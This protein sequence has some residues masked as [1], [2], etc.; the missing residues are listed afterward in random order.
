MG[1]QAKKNFPMGYLS[2]IKKKKTLAA[3]DVG[4]RLGRAFSCHRAVS[5]LDKKLRSIYC[6][7]SSA[8]GVPA[9]GFRGNRVMNFSVA[10]G[11]GEALPS[12]LASLFRAVYAFRVTWSERF[13][14]RIRHRNELT[15]KAWEDAVQGLGKGRQGGAQE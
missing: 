11:L 7:W 14:S 13:S 15:E 1:Q 5:L 4:A 9:I 8:K 3:R 12:L 6:V 2:P 10:S